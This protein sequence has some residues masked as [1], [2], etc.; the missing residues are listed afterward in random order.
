MSQIDFDVINRYLD[1]ERVVPE[2]LPDGKRQGREWSCRNPNRADRSPGSFMVNLHNGKWSDFASGDKG[3]DLVSLYAYLRCGG[4]QGKAARELCEQFNITIDAAA[5]ERVANDNVRHLPDDKPVP[6]IPVPDGV[7]APSARDFKHFKF[8]SPTRT[9]TYRDAEGHVLLYVCRFEPEG[10][11][12]QVVPLSWCRDPKR[13]AERWAWRGITK[14]KNPLYGLDRL[15]ASPDADVVMVEGEKAADAANVL[16]APTGAVAATW[17]GGVERAGNIDVRALKGRRVILW[18][19]FD[20]QAEKGSGK[21]LPM[22]EQPGV[23]AMMAIAAQLKGV[24]SDVTMVGYRFDQFE[25][26]WDLADAEADGWDTDRVMRYMAEHSGDPAHIASGNA[27]SEEG[28]RNVVPLDSLVSPF[29]FP[30][31]TDKGGPLSTIEN[32]QYLLDQYDITVRYNVISKDVETNINGVRFSQDNNEQNMLTSV[33]SLCSRNRMPR[34]DLKDYLLVIAATNERNPAAEWIDSRPWD[35][36]DRMGALVDTLDPL[37]RE[38]AYALVRRWM[39]GAAGCVYEP[40][41][42]SMQGVLVLQGPQNSGK[43][44]WF[45][46]LTNGNRRL[47]KEGTTLN[48]ADRDSVKQA[49]SYWLVELGELDATFRK[50]DVAALKAFL[51]KDQDELRLPF[52]KASSKYPR[53]TAFVA[54]VN[55]QQYLHDDTGNR[56]YWTVRHGPNMRGLHDVDMQQAWAQAKHLWKSGEQHR[57]TQDELDRLN[58]ANAEHAEGSAIEELIL[59]S[60]AWTGQADAYPTWMSATEVLIA[61]GQDRPNNKQTKEC[62]AVLRKLVGE[63]KK[64]NGLSIYPMPKM[65]R[66][67]LSSPL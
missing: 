21:R 31:V 7:G 5:R 54:T 16:L 36:V 53:R 57:L 60:F 61:I 2:W 15:A 27:F 12:K 18:P 32:L 45:W 20:D 13:D 37:D 8:G 26:G 9:W 62:S 59:S 58:A 67:L 55:P 64:R 43:T 47:A 3:G 35:G 46:S 52:A 44:T 14:G 19:D 33:G 29:G 41:G 38:L 22:H 11:R 10:M 24:A 17:M 40:A 66:Q 51:T 65:K 23:R 56:R 25:H 63:P 6:I 28:A 30:H 34:G 48:P 39:I 42:I 4:D 49:V 50:S 1:A